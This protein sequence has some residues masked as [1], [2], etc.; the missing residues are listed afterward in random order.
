MLHTDSIEKYFLY[1]VYSIYQMVGKKKK[2]IK[3][4]TLI[5]YLYQQNLLQNG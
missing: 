1:D 4:E 3:K 2:K 5:K